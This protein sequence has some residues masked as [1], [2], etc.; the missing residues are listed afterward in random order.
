M[1]DDKITEIEEILFN[2]FNTSFSVNKDV[3]SGYIL[4]PDDTLKLARELEL[5]VHSVD[6]I[7][8]LDE[9]EMAV[10]MLF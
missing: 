5:D 1:K 2:K 9:I 6:F 3:V 7:D 10:N 4:I 8:K